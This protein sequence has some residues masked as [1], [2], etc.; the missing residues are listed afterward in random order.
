[1]NFKDKMKPM[2][3]ASKLNFS[4]KFVREHVY[5]IRKKLKKLKEID[6]KL[7]NQLMTSHSTNCSKRLWRFS[8]LCLHIGLIGLES[9]ISY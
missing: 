1:M 3:I 6:N 4:I 8:I 7:Q 5:L 9:M 2:H